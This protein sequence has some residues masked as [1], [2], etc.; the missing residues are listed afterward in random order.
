MTPRDFSWVLQP[1]HPRGEPIALVWNLDTGKH[2]CGAFL[3]ELV[4]VQKEYGKVA[5]LP[6]PQNIPFT[7]PWNKP[8]QLVALLAHFW[9]LPPEL[10][11]EYPEPEDQ[12]PGNP[13]VVY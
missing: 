13:D 10:M 11:K 9:V 2:S 6:P 3:D 7:D 8:E 12:E 4:K 1:N 5:I